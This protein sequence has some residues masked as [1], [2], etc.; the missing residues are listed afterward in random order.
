LKNNKKT[1]PTTPAFTTAC[2]SI[3]PVISAMFCSKNGKGLTTSVTIEPE[4]I[5]LEIV[6]SL[7]Q[8]SKFVIKNVSSM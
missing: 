8:V 5:F 7:L 6:F 3:G 1:K 4:I 2:N